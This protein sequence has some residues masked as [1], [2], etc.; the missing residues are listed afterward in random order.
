MYLIR[1]QYN[2]NLFTKRHPALRLCGTIGNFDGFH[3]GHQ[4]ILKKIK[5]DAVDLNAKTIV[6]ITEPHAAEYFAEKS[7]PDK[8]PPRILP[9]IDKVKLLND[10]G[11]DY[12]FILKFDKNLRAMSPESFIKDILDQVGLV[13]LTVGDDFR[14]GLNRAGDFHQLESWGSKK[15]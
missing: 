15:M 12:V 2:L 10:F 11:I 14:F 13:S 6:F 4:S 5:S 3:L 8:I 1:G 9:W 7:D